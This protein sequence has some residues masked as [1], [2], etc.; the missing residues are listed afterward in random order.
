MKISEVKTGMSG[1]TI[2]LFSSSQAVLTEVLHSTIIRS[3]VVESL[4]CEL[5]PTGNLLE[6]STSS[7]TPAGCGEIKKSWFG[8]DGT[9][10]VI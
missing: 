5:F 9:L 7:H 3:N 1:E 6:T 8:L 10:Q 2:S 4:G